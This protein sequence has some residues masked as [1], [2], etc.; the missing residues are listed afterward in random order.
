MGFVTE[1]PGLSNLLVYLKSVPPHV[2]TGRMSNAQVH[3]PRL[4]KKI[5][6]GPARLTL[7]QNSASKRYADIA[8]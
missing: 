7:H 8:I 1:L 6:V 3:L 4:L 5:R 2:C